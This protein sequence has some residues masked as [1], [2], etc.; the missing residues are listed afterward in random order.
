MFAIITA[1]IAYVRL[2]TAIAMIKSVGLDFVLMSD[3]QRDVELEKENI[4]YVLKWTRYS[5]TEWFLLLAKLRNSIAWKKYY[6]FMNDPQ[7]GMID[8]FRKMGVQVKNAP[9]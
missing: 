6:L 4:A 2:R 5:G 7:Y 9:E 8:V 3:G 1:L